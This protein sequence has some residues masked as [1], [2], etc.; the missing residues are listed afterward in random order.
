MNG[1]NLQKA[2]EL[3]LDFVDN[4]NNNDVYTSWNST[5]PF[6]TNQLNFLDEDGSQQISIVK[7]VI[8]PKILDM[9][10]RKQER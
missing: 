10:D 8:Y 2:I 1:P 3:C 7:T 6:L 4:L 9:I 5:F